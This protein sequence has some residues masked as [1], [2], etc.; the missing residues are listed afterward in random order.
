MYDLRRLAMLLTVV[1]AAAGIDARVQAQTRVAIPS[2]PANPFT[3]PPSVAAPAVTTPVPTLPSTA[4]PYSSPYAAPANPYSVAPTW[5]PYGPAGGV[6]TP[7]PALP[8]YGQQPAGGGMLQYPFQDWGN[9]DLSSYRLLNN[10]TVRHSILIGDGAND[11]GMNDLDLNTSGVTCRP[12][13][14]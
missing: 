9:T 1:A 11:F 14:R 12:R 4:A 13:R 3:T 10:V 7:A 8:P 2:S 5:D 6:G